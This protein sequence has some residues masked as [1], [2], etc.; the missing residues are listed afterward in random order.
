MTSKVDLEKQLYAARV[1]I[2]SLRTRVDSLERQQKYANKRVSTDMSVPEIIEMS[3]DQDEQTI[4]RIISHETLLSV[5]RALTV[6][7]SST[8]THEFSYYSRDDDIIQEQRRKYQ[9]LEDR[10]RSLIIE[11]MTNG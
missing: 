4:L 8:R 11:R 10:V 1:E 5:Y 6:F 7:Y 3:L 2:G 9:E